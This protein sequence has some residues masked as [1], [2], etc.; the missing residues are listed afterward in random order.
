M[1]GLLAGCCGWSMTVVALGAQRPGLALCT[2][3]L[4]W[5]GMWLGLEDEP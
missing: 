4:G 5:A 2:F 3:V 1:T